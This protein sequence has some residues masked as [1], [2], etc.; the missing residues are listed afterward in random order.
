MMVLIGMLDEPV[1]MRWCTGLMEGLYR[2]VELVAIS[3]QVSI[4]RYE[5]QLLEAEVKWQAQHAQQARKE[6]ASPFLRDMFSFTEAHHGL[7]LPA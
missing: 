3:D 5:L 4:L 6:T 1:E 2:Q 7:F